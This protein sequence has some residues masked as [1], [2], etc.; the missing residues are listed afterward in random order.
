MSDRVFS[1]TASTLRLRRAPSTDAPIVARL[2]RGQLVA[3]LDLVDRGSWWRV[4]ADTPGSGAYVGYVDKSWLTLWSEA[5][6][7]AA[8]APAPAPTPAPSPTA[9]DLAPTDPAPAPPRRPA[10][11]PPGPAEVALV[12]T[13]ETF[14]AE[15]SRLGVGVPEFWAVLEV[16]ARGEGFFVGGAKHRLP[17]ILY[18]RHIFSDQTRGRFDRSNPDISSPRPYTFNEN[19]APEDRYGPYDGQYLRLAAAASLDRRAALMSASWGIAQIMGFNHGHAG[20]DDVETMV[21]DMRRSE[22]LQFRAFVSFIL[23]HDLADA[24]QRRDWTTFA[25]GYNGEEYWKNKYDEKLAARHAELAQ[26]PPDML[27][28]QAQMYLKFLNLYHD[29]ADGIWGPKS[30]AAV[31]GYLHAKGSPARPDQLER[32]P[33]PEFLRELIAEAMHDAAAHPPPWPLGD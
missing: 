13:P 15:A 14:A 27:L 3:R 1:V 2:E 6:P 32:Q 33:G 21:A 18:E 12:L 20:Y 17:Q 11:T 22:D 9:P 29:K 8:P 24:L 25:R 16:E 5:P 26:R 4:F 28:R 7:V 10:P 23:S 19:A 30:R 31:A